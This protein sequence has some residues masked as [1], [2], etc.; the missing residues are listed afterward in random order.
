MLCK[1]THCA[2]HVWPIPGLISCAGVTGRWGLLSH[3]VPM[4][5]SPYVH[6]EW[7]FMT[8]FFCSGVSFTGC[9]TS[10]GTLHCHTVEWEQ[11]STVSSTQYIMYYIVCS[12]PH[13]IH[14]NCT[15]NKCCTID[16]CRNG[17][18]ALPHSGV[19]TDETVS[20]TQYIM[21]LYCL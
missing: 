15:L 1:V 4:Y 21:Y 6:S 13:N 5:W 16:K 10:T 18:A 9:L 12:N 7:C 20:S 2:G 3:T 11:T 14:V 19:G 8:S 17:L